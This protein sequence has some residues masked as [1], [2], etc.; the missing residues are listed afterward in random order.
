MKLSASQIAARINRAWWL[1]SPLRPDISEWSPLDFKLYD[2]FARMFEF[3]ARIKREQEDLSYL[4]EF[5][6]RMEWVGET[7]EYAPEHEDVPLAA[8]EVIEWVQSFWQTLAVQGLLPGTYDDAVDLLVAHMRA[9]Q[10]RQVRRREAYSTAGSKTHYMAPREQR[11]EITRP[12]MASWDPSERP[13]LAGRVLRPDEYRRMLALYD[14]ERRE[15]HERESERQRKER[16]AKGERT[17]KVGEIE[18]TRGP[19]GTYTASPVQ[20]TGRGRK[21]RGGRKR[22]R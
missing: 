4:N 7:Y 10:E 2:E 13:V 3:L 15:R 12:G 18:V 5:V 16:M 1:I 14:E 22:R 21:R 17:R 20:P 11:I 6:S 8:R 9:S 19:R